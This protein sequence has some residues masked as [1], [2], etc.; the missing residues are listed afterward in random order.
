[1]ATT[2]H[3]QQHLSLGNWGLDPAWFTRRW[4]SVAATHAGG[5]NLG[6]E[7][8]AAAQTH[9]QVSMGYVGYVACV[10]VVLVEQCRSGGALTGGDS[11]ADICAVGHIHAF[12]LVLARFRQLAKGDSA[13]NFAFLA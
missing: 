6:T 1:V 7:S 13:A 2:G 10:D 8:R 3:I 11:G 12:L 5:L 4:F 9:G